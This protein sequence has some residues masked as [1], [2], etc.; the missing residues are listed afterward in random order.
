MQIIFRFFLIIFF[1]FISTNLFAEFKKNLNG[2]TE[3]ALLIEETDNKCGVKK[4]N[5]EA[6]VE[7]LINTYPGIKINDNAD[8]YLWISTILFELDNDFACSGTLLM[9]LQSF[10]A[11][12]D[13]F[14]T[15]VFWD[16][17]SGQVNNPQDF[18]NTFLD[19]INKKIKIFLSD[20]SRDN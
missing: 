18:S 3:I 1:T 5:I 2:I 8:H 12:E 14:V 6:E 9:R 19:K 17:Y 7:Y 10:T 20:W 4:R 16:D 13:K 15:V 11:H